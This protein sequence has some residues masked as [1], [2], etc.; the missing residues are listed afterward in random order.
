MQ[1]NS[2]NEIQEA[3]LYELAK[4]TLAAEQNL[5]AQVKTRS[6]VKSPQP[7]S[8]KALAEKLTEIYSGIL[9]LVLLYQLQP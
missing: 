2:T 9:Q 3:S 7:A 1:S 8:V 6:R 4:A 5:H